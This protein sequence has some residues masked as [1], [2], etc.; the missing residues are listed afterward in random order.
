MGKFIDLTGRIYGRLTI[1]GPAEPLISPTRWGCRCECGTVKTIIGAAMKNGA[2]KSCGC[3]HIDRNKELFTKHGDFEG[4]LYRVRRA[5]INRCENPKD[6][7]YALY[8]GRGITICEAWHDYPTFKAWAESSGYKA[9][10][11]LDRKDP[12]KGYSPENCRWATMTTQARNRRQQPGKSSPYIGVTW[13]TQRAKWFSSIGVNKKTVAL[14]R[15]INPIAAAY[16]RDNYITQ[17]NLQDFVLNF[18]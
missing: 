14:G 9:G 8:G 7:H 3:L 4:K 16:A 18:P 5:M 11:T 12:D 17:N 6:K 15:F 2:T 1:L 10:L 13:D